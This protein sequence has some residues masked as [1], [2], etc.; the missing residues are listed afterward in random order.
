MNPIEPWVNQS[1]ASVAR[2]YSA[3]TSFPDVKQQLWLWATQNHEKV[4]EYLAH[5]EG[6]RIIRSILNQEARN[7]AI[8]ERAMSSGYEFDDVAWYTVTAI[9]RV[10]PDVF[11]YEDWQTFEM[12]S[13]GPSNKPAAWSGDKLATLIDIKA[14]LKALSDDRVMLLREHYGR[15]ASVEACAIALGIEPDACRKRIQRALKTLSN[16][17]NNPRQSDPYE[18]ATYEQ[19]KASQAFYDTRTKGRKAISNATARKRTEG[20]YE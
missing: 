18:G 2:A 16:A 1:A 3:W 6:E 7:Y 9:K 5:P 17:L 20:N 15:G 12:K 14:G 13:D 4:T 8:R 19:W 11:D 10:L